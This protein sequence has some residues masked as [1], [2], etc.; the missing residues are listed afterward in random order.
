MLVL[1]SSAKVLLADNGVVLTATSTSSV[2]GTPWV[3][4]ILDTT[5]KTVVA[6]CTE[7]NQC[8]VFY[9][10][11]GGLHSFAAYVTD[12][13]LKPT[14]V[15][16]VSN[17]VAV[18]WVALTLTSS[19][20]S[21]VAPGAPVT[22]TASSTGDVAKIGTPLEILDTTIGRRLT[23]CS[24]GFSCSTV[25]TL[26]GAGTH[27][28]IARVVN[29]TQT[30]PVFVTW[31]SVNVA[32]TTTNQPGAVIHV[33]A[34]TNAKMDGTPWT[35]FIT[36]DLYT[37]VL[38]TCSTGSFCRAD[39][40][41]PDGR[42]PAYTAF[43]A[44]ARHGLLGSLVA[45]VTSTQ[46][47]L[48]SP[49]DIQARSTSVKPDRKLWGVDSCK[50]MTA[51]SSGSSG[52]Y[53]QVVAAY[54]GKPDFWGRY[55]TGTPYCPGIS[56][57]EVAAAHAQHVGILPIYNYYDCSVVSTYSIG[58]QYAGEA[59]TAAQS[60]GIPARTGLVVDIEPA[61]GA[62]PGAASVDSGF[63]LGWYDGVKRGGYVPIYYG[64]S[65]GDAPFANAWCSAVATRAS[66][67]NDA[68]VWSFEPSLLGT[69]TKG[70]APL[71]A[72]YWPGCNASLQAWQYELSAG[73]T[74][75][76]DQD[77]A[78]GTLPLWFP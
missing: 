33:Y 58:M 18:V 15:Q 64:N 21:A 70:T 27:S 8:S 68:I 13:G 40:T 54:G 34:T 29:V 37:T 4:E 45:R 24:M 1:A 5:T 47:E 76:V 53:P 22:L 26:P 41:L 6:S 35:I 10:T 73:S 20:P 61:E 17:S 16:A 69:Y 50:A 42:T 32:A 44:R 65:A 9:S 57:A 25:V 71:Y 48:P 28:F 12:P 51:D 62:C 39:F 23:W 66:I 75:D 63:I 30:A 77:Q 14:D 31:L 2:T 72:P 43:V 56:A 55:L 7:T 11:T 3:I 52:L 78:T 67:I 49:A 38:K 46:S 59:V 60:L 74:P 36:D 19:Y